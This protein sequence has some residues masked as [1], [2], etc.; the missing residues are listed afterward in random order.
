M[1][2]SDGQHFFKQF[3][4]RFRRHG[5]VHVIAEEARQAPPREAASFNHALRADPGEVSSRTVRTTILAIGISTLFLI[6]CLAAD[7]D[8]APENI[9]KH[10]EWCAAAR[11]TAAQITRYEGFWKRHHPESEEYEDAIGVRFVRLCAYRLAALYADAG[12]AKKCRAMIQWLEA[13]DE[14]LR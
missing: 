14:R 5:Q 2:D 11:D 4:A 3:A 1:I 7:T 10:Y 6:R 13:N 12:N 8:K 9:M